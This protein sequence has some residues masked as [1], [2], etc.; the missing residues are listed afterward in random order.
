MSKKRVFFICILLFLP[1]VLISLLVFIFDP[2][3][4]YHKPLPKYPYVLENERYQNDGIA[5]HFDYELLI[6]GSST[7]QVLLPSHASSLWGRNAIRTSFAGGSLKETG[8]LVDTAITSN[9]NLKVVIRGLDLGRIVQDKD[10]LD[11]DDIPFYL[12][13]K[14]PFNDYKYLYNKDVML[15]IAGSLVKQIRR[16]S[17]DSFD[18]YENWNDTKTFGKDAILS[19]FERIDIIENKQI[20]TETDRAKTN[21]NLYENILKTAS[22]NP[23]I[24]FIIFIPP[25]NVL[26]WDAALRSG[27][28]EYTLDALDESFSRLLEAENI[29]IYA[30]DDCT[31]I[32][33][34]FNNYI[35][36]LHF[37]EEI[38]T[39]ILDSI[40]S[41]KHRI[42][43]ANKDEYLNRLHD[44]YTTYNYDSIF[45]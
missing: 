9:N 25:V 8:E 38:G 41:G 33:C 2:F 17:P 19:G 12:Y 15:N 18:D 39:Y 23:D 21:D 20:Y 6:T 4:H 13:D 11:Y 16:Q 35:D 5:K 30:F 3:F 32:T 14:N 42:T 26:Y 24:D 7:S 10:T 1:S 45:N 22:K 34:D 31:E 28:F 44:I 36:T 29:E 37:S 27:S 40:Y 43:K